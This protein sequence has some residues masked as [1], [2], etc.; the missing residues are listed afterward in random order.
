MPKGFRDMQKELE[1]RQ[2]QPNKWN[3][4][5][6]TLETYAENKRKVDAGLLPKI[7]GGSLVTPSNPDLEHVC[8]RVKDFTNIINP[9]RRS[10]N[11]K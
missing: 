4:S 11:L 5:P 7:I 10:N 8:R 2:K 3:L 9:K 1:S 6:E